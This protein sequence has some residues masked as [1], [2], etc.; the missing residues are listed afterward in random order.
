MFF[1][2]MCESV[3]KCTN[4]HRHHIPR[5][6][7]SFLSCSLIQTSENFRKMTKNNILHFSRLGHHRHNQNSILLIC[8]FWMR[9]DV[10]CKHPLGHIHNKSSSLCIRSTAV[11][12][13]FQREISNFSSDTFSLFSLYFIP[14]LAQKIQQDPQ[15][16]IET[17]I[18]IVDQ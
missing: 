10:K 9:C 8:I 6:G 15:V 16:K 13:F 14:N 17:F 3:N 11:I 4:F 2:K 12:S 1:R 7:D 18:F 5:G